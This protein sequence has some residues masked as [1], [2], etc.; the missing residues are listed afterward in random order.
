MCNKL[1]DQS[2][3][4]NRVVVDGNLITS[5]GPGTSMEFALAIVEKLF[6]RQNALNLA[7]TLVFIWMRWTLQRE[8][9]DC[10]QIMRLWGSSCFLREYYYLGLC[11]K[12][13]NWD[14]VVWGASIRCTLIAAFH[15]YPSNHQLGMLV[16]GKYYHLGL[17]M[18]TQDWVN[19]IWSTSICCSLIAACHIYPFN[20]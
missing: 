1:S 17:C 7:K 19:V 16:C 11:I 14:N 6:G 4:E 12:L 10:W 20:R 15:I 8:I 13:E 2:E 9:C 18:K 3:C 5:R